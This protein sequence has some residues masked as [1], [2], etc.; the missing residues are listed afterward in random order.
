YTESRI[1]KARL[2]FLRENYCIRENDFLSFD[3]MRHAAQCLG[4]VLR[5]KDDYGIMV[6]ADR[7][8]QKK[9]SQLP[10]WINQ[11]L[12]ESETNLSTDMAVATAKS[13]LRTMA[14]PFKAKDQEGISTWSLE[15]LQRHV[16]KEEEEVEKRLLAQMARNQGRFGAPVAQAPVQ[17]SVEE[18]DDLD[19]EDLMA[20]AA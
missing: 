8:F 7:R 10:K 17:A 14:Q 19:D 4:R 6:L 9:R 20:M 2:E 5:G 11:A 13:F 18:Y 16:R 1:L 12:L 3:A 15:D